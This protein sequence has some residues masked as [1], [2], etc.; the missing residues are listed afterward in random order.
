MEIDDKIYENNI[1]NI[2]KNKEIYDIFCKTN[3]HIKYSFW[4]IKKLMIIIILDIIN[5]SELIV[6]WILEH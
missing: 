3:Q 4:K 2:Y 6:I 5:L 1:N